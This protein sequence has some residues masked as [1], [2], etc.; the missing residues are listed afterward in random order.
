MS[1]SYRITI[2]VTTCQYDIQQ[3][4]TMYSNT[5]Q[6]SANSACTN[7]S[8]PNMNTQSIPTETD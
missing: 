1:Y 3:Y 4:V 6:N 7:Y 5:K 8:K 2:T